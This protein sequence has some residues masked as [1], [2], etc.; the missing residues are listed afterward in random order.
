MGILLVRQR[1]TVSNRG[2]APL[3]EPGEQ[4]TLATE[5]TVAALL[6]IALAA[7]CGCST[8]QTF[9][10]RRQLDAGLYEF[11]ERNFAAAATYLYQDGPR[12]WYATQATV[13]KLAEDRAEQCTEELASWVMSM[14]PWVEVVKPESLRARVKEMLREGLKLYA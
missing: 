4:S 14:A 11:A 5:R 9:V 3:R 6:F 2:D 8:T 1:R 7:L 12:F 10:A 13:T